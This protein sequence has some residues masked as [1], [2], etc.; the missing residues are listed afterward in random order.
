M[1]EH[2]EFV[3]AG[4][5]MK[6]QLS[7]GDTNGAFSLFEN[8]SSGQSKTPIHVHA[9]DDET[10]FIIEGEMKAIIAGEEQTIKAGESIFLPRGIPHQLMNTSGYPSRYMLLCTPSGFEGFLSEGGHLKEPDEVV[11][12]PTP[13]DIER[14]KK[15]APKFGITLLPGW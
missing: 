12:P 4:V 14:L 9:D 8:R 5:V 7:G 15:A 1:T 13:E 6:Q 2:K 3:L 10:L 11:G